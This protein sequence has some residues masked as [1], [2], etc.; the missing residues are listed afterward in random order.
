MRNPV[1]ALVGTYDLNDLVLDLLTGSLGPTTYNNYGTGV[2]RFTVFCNEEGITQLEATAADML[3]FTTWLARAG[4]IAANSLQPYFSAIN[5]FFRDQLKE[6]VALGPLLTDAR[7]GLAMQQPP[8]TD[9]DIRVPISAPIVQHMLLFAH[10]HYRALTW[11]PDNLVQIKT[12]RA[13]LAVCT[14]YCYFRRAET[15]VRCH[16]DDIAVD[17]TGGNIL[18]FIRK[19]KGDER[20]TAADKPLLQLPI[21]AVPLLADLMEAFTVVRTR[22]CNQ[23]GNEPGP[24]TFWAVTRDEHPHTWTAG[25][26]TEWIR[27]ACNSIGATPPP[28]FKWTSHSLQRGAASAAACIGAPLTKIFCMGGWS[29]TNDVVTGKYINPNMI[30][31]PTILRQASRQT[32]G[33]VAYVDLQSL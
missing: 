33:L 31:T 32:P 1:G 7:R 11:Q 6:P 2:R 18:L 26:I 27:E 12:F 24:T 17:R 5:K 8:I 21:T 16:M 9:P 14:N 10:R 22:Y 29:K 3:R 15:G 28:K 23:L 30:E 25:T 13:I 19:A 4:T 20:R